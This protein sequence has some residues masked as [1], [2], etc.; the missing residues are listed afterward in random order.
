MS[1]NINKKNKQLEYL[2]QRLGSIKKKAVGEVNLEE[3]ENRFKENNPRYEI[4]TK[5]TNE[6]WQKQNKY[7]TLINDRES[8]KKRLDSYK[9]LI[10]R[11]I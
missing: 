10:A 11:N 6:L 9:E 1:V 3:L 8:V 7:L 5:E 2:K 4:L